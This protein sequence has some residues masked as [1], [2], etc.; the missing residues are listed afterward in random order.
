EEQQTT[1]L[2]PPHKSVQSSNA[3]MTQPAASLSKVATLT[4]A[5]IPL[6]ALREDGRAELT[7][8]LESLPGPKCV[9]LERQMGGLLNH[10]IPEASKLMKEKGVVHCRE[11]SAE[12]GFG[13]FLDADGRP[14]DPQPEHIVYLVR[15]KI[16]HMTIIADQIKERELQLLHTLQRYNVCFAPQR[17]LICEQVLQS[18][19]ALQHVDV[20]EYP[21]DLVPLD[22]DLL[23]LELDGFWRECC[24]EGDTSGLTAIAHSINR[25]QTLFGT[26]PNVKV[27]GELSKAALQR[28]MQIRHETVDQDTDT[29]LPVESEIDTLVMI[30][31]TVDYASA[32]VTPLTYEG[33]VHELIG[34]VHGFV[35]VK[36][37]VVDAPNTG[38]KSKARQEGEQ[39]KQIPISLNSNDALYSAIRD[40][41]VEQLGPYLQGKAKEI[42]ESYSTFRSNRDKSITQIHDFVKRIPDLT[43]NYHSLNTHINIAELI[44]HSTSSSEF[45]SRWQMERTMLEGDTAYSELGERINTQEPVLQILRLICIES[46]TKGGI[47]SSKYDTLRRDII[48]V[49]GYKYMLVLANLEKAGLLKRRESTWVENKPAWGLLRQSLNLIKDNVSVH[50]P[51]DIAYVSSGY[52]P[53]SVR[54]VQAAASSHGWLGAGDVM[55]L[56]S[57]PTIEITQQGKPETLEAAMKRPVARK[58]VPSQHKKVMMVYYV[59]GVTFL[60]IAALRLLSKQKEFPFHIII[61]ATKITS[62]AELIQ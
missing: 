47:V 49:Y 18:E 5:Q 31:R 56:L 52:A 29:E 45:R 25:L 22:A 26:I 17:T 19:G 2:H 32:M 12:D 9:V 44:K 7:A 58:A 21:L 48:Q 15:P 40:L 10:V 54:L 61:A 36:A 33:L 42:R 24:V 50:E 28:A 27:K 41:N 13:E 62:G 34:I 8:L 53:L 35:K 43:Q 11:L 38:S 60:E 51:N 3:Q 4:G 6:I 46:I 59:G 20:R 16:A 30:D 14:I 39:V 1:S 55:K 57:G 23:S 37:D